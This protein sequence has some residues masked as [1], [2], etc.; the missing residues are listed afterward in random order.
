MFQAPSLDV[1]PHP[2]ANEGYRF[3]GWSETDPANGDYTL[4]DPTANYITGDKT[5]YAVYEV[6]EAE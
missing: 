5:F 2:V 6:Y 3:A 1:Y 4:M